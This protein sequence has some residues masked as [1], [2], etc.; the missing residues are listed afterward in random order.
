M[1]ILYVS[2]YFSPE[3]GAPSARV[4]ELSKHWVE[5]GHQVTVLTGFPNHPT[6]VVHPG[7]R[8]KMRRLIS[9]EQVD[10]I[11]VVRTW[12]L[13]KPNRRPL[14]R[15]LN[16]ASFWL[17]S[18]VTGTFLSKPDVIIGTSPQLLAGL[19]GWWLSQ[20]K[21]APFVLEIRDLWPESLAASGVGSE[22]SMTTKLVGRL[23]R[24]LYDHSHHVV[25]VTPAFK[26]RLLAD[27]DVSSEKCSIVN[28]GVETELFSP[29]GDARQQKEALG[30]G[31]KFV[32]SYVGT[33]GMAHGLAMI[34]QAAEQMR[35]SH[36]DVLFMLI[37]EGA[38]RE[39]LENETKR[40]GLSNV[41]FVSQKPRSEIPRYIQAS[42]VCLVLLRKAD[43]F[44]TVIPTKMLEFMSCGR[45][46]ILG[47]DGQ[48]REIIEEAQAGLFIEPENTDAL[49]QGIDQLYRDQGLRESLGRGGRKYIVERLS[50]RSTAQRYIEVLESVVSTHKA[51]AL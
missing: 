47:V 44:R 4:H 15:I 43:T 49:V 23:A 16:Y 22:G 41:T 39:H 30:V 13:P 9:R 6:G 2:Q 5:A 40:R 25:V 48:A 1:K 27:W 10:G 18:S 11:D 12:L 45:P 17:S 38:E 31:D 36:P 8:A 50:R 19:T 24:F 33:L 26:D 34:L 46:V 20:A 28:N 3:M 7:Y 42:D 35:D 37:G 14:E 21:G 51:E 32:V 29:D